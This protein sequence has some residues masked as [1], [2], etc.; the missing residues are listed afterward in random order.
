M[1]ISIS[2][3]ATTSCAIRA[4][5]WANRIS[6]AARSKL[7]RRIWQ[8]R[9]GQPR[10]LFRTRSGFA[11]VPVPTIRK[12]GLWGQSMAA[13]TYRYRAFISYRHVERDRRWARWLIEKLE[14]FRTPKT[15][16]RAGAPLQIGHLFRD[17]DEIPA[18]SDLSHQIEDA[19]KA[20]QFLIVV[21]SRDTPKSQWVGREIEFFRKLGR[22]DRIL[23]LLTDGEPEEAFPREL[24]HAFDGSAGEAN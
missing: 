7:C 14:T 12:I 19:L 5:R 22:A 8:R 4:W 11:L 21:C 13:E 20:S 1:S 6:W 18:S 15:L 24:L 9:C 10:R 16:V 2:P 17:D 3:P 23:A